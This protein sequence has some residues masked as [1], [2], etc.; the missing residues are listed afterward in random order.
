MDLPEHFRCDCVPWLGPAHCHPCSDIAGH[1]VPWS[2][3]IHEAPPILGEGVVRDHTATATRY[4][5]DVEESDVVFFGHHVARRVNG[6]VTITDMRLG[7]PYPIDP[8]PVDRT[9]HEARS[10]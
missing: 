2:E 9:G 5:S 4:K 8:E 7:L 10:Q 6:W 3:S 1:E